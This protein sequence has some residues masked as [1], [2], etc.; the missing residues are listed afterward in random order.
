MTSPANV[1]VVV[2]PE[3]KQ[4]TGYA[5]LV[6]ADGTPWNPGG[7]FTP[8]EYVGNA[9][10]TSLETVASGIDAIRDA[11]VAAGLMADD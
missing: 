1:F 3:G 7:S 5:S 4:P 10:D 6:N 2:P 8:A 11:L 9:D